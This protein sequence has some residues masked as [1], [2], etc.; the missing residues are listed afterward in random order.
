LNCRDVLNEVCQSLMPLAEEKGIALSVSLA[1]PD[2]TV[3]SDRRWLSQI[4]INLTG[5][6]IKFTDEGSVTIELDQELSGD[7]TSI[8]RFRVIDTGVGI[9]ADEQERLFSAFEQIAETRR[10][11]GTGLG[12]YIS[13][14]LATLI[15]GRISSESEYGK[16]STFVLEL[17]GG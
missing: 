4:L 9:R 13:Q 14:R 10:R 8:T 5:N 15:D 12:L 3:R 7:W 6:A 17:G 11:E 1:N 16:G 2:S